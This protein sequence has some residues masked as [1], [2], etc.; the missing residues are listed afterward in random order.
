MK[1]KKIPLG[2]SDFK[3]LIEGNY[4]YIDKTKL[5]EDILTDG[6][7]VNLFTRPRRFGKTLNMSMLKYFFDVE[8]VEENKKIFKDLYIEKSE[9]FEKQGQHPVIFISLKNLSANSWGEMKKG[10]V[11]FIG[12]LFHENKHLYGEL[13]K[14]DKE[15]FEKILM[16]KEEAEN[17]KE[18]LKFL[19]KTLYEKYNKKVVVLI[20][21]YDAPIISA[22]KD[23]YYKEAISF[24]KELYSSALKDNEYLELGV[25]TGILQVA[26]EGI[27]SGLNNIIA[28]NILE[29]GYSSSFGFVQE[30]VERALLDFELG[31]NIEDVK[32]WYDGYRFGETEIYN[33]WSILTYLYRREL[34]AYWVNT[35]S[36]DLITQVLKQS[37]DDVFEELK[38]LF[39][40]GLIEKSIN[41]HFNFNEM[42]KTRGLW[43][44][45]IFS[46]YLKVEEK[47][48]KDDYNDDLYLLKIPNLE[49]KSFFYRN[50]IDNFLGGVDVFREMQN[51][52]KKKDEEVFT[53]KLQTIFDVS[54]SYYDL[55]RKEKYYHNIFLGMII[56]MGRE[57]NI[58]S[59]K[60]A[61]QGRYD[62]LLEPK[63]KIKTGFVL[64]FKVAKNDKE[65]EKLSVE[66]IEQIK[67]KG[68]VS[69]MKVKGINDILGV[70]IAFYKKKVK[71]KFE[72]I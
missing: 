68:Y 45:F 34:G 18:T 12:T 35:S 23:G 64:E 43:E 53:E 3:S 6:F 46:G 65:L 28:H 2:T 70:G 27:F 26:K 40:D 48:R 50:F 58:S 56:T 22:Y 24:F 44:L 7:N 33:P 31:D 37:G 30:E 13:D 14:F 25:L 71:V 57:Y 32:I 36:N 59:N 41:K 72:E 61:G 67:D 21:E 16:R 4:Y 1:K 19:C 5:I 20:D 62:I 8:N 29:K 10:I 69:S 42:N 49:I 38:T 52:L 11:N 55:G 54:V 60:E 15:I 9:Y 66:A 17:L 39:S 47:V 63:D 51:A